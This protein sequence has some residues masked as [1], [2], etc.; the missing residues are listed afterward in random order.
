MD[1][2]VDFW[3][4]L[5][6][7]WN[8]FGSQNGI[9]KSMKFCMSFWRRNWANKL[10]IW[11]RPGGMRGVPGGIIGGYKDAKIA[12]ET[13]PENQGQ[14]QGILG[15]LSSTPFPVGRRIASRIPPGRS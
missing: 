8:H 12:G 10:V 1:F 4:I 7:F 2:G 15:V 3:W 5:E 11:G 13:R 6:G 14:E 9:K